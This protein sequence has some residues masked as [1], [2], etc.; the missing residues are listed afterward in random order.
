VLEDLR[1]PTG[2]LTFAAKKRLPVIATGYA[3]DWQGFWRRFKEEGVP[4]VLTGQQ[5]GWFQI[6]DAQSLPGYI[7]R[8]ALV[9]EALGVPPDAGLSARKYEALGK[10]AKAMGHAAVPLRPID[11]QEWQLGL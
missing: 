6:G 2:L 3:V 10:Q 11:P 1:T 5:R 4:V 8:V 9:V 7:I